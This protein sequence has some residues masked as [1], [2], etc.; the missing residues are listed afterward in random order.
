MYYW[1]WQYLRRNHTYKECCDSGGSGTASA[2]YRDFGDVHAHDFR[3]WWNAD[4]RGAKLFAERSR[5]IKQMRLTSKDQWDE[6]WSLEDAAVFVFPLSVGRRKIQSLFAKQLAKIHN[7]K[8][9]R[10]SLATVESTA[11][12]P[13]HRNFNVHTLKTGLALYDAS[14][15]NS[16]LPADERAPL[17]RLGEL[18]MVNPSANPMPDDTKYERT[19]KRNVLTVTVSRHLSVTKRVIANTL[20]GRFPDAST[21]N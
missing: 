1:W 11:L 14:V 8:R 6:S 4:D 16:A 5:E 19:S 13:L 15:L 10:I 12:Y 20:Y 18:L 3:T 9:G 17:W 21:V 2:L 7:G